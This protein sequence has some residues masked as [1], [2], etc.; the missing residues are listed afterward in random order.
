MDPEILSIQKVSDG[1]LVSF[2]EGLN[3]Y[4]STVFL[5]EHAGSGSNVIFLKQDPSG[6][7]ELSLLSDRLFAS[8]SPAA[9]P[10]SAEN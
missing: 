8:E 5:L 3:C 10:N 9:S 1:I 6:P 2:A 7:H 4:Y